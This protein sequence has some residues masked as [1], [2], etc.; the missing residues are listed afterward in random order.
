[1]T[2]MR[3]PSVVGIPLAFTPVVVL[4]KTAQAEATIQSVQDEYKAGRLT[5]PRPAK[6][7]RETGSKGNAAK[8]R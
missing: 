3:V 8:K 2:F 1:M 5:S 6:R 4:E 7:A